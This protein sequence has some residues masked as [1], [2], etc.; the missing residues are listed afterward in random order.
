ML[1]RNYSAEAWLANRELSSVHG[2]TARLWQRYS[3]WASQLVLLGVLVAGAGLI[4]AVVFW[5]AQVDQNEPRVPRGGPVQVVEGV[6]FSPDRK[7]LAACGCDGTVSVWDVDQI[8]DESSSAPVVLAHRSSRYA[9][10][11]SPNGKLLATAGNRSIAVWSCEASEY[12][13]LMDEDSETCRCLAF[14]PDGRSL[15]I[16]MDDGSIHLWDVPSW[17]ERAVVPAHCSVV[18]SLA[19]SPDSRRLVSS[20]QNKT[21]M[22]SDAVEGVAIRSLGTERLVHNP[23]LIVAFSPDGHTLAVGQVGVD[24]ENVALLDS[25]SGKVISLLAGHKTG[26]H[27]LAF[28]PDGRTLATAAID[29]SIKLW[30]VSTRRELTTLQSGVSLVKSISFSSDGAWLAF[31]AGK[32]SVQVWDVARSKSFLLS[33]VQGRGPITTMKRPRRHQDKPDSQTAPFRVSFDLGP[34]VAKVGGAS[35]CAFWL[36]ATCTANSI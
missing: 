5:P 14:S 11:F 29:S 6:A 19:F 22:L 31:G 30:D 35:S 26:V 2:Q 21:I 15:A 24:P 8:G 12:T 17:H 10:A 33:R 32:D 18:R 23:V 27:A 9:V 1:A 36:L 25:E 16:G 3:R 4:G 34:D 28:S 13:A 7:M 20:D